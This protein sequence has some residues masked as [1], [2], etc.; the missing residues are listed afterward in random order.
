MPLKLIV[1]VSDIYQYPVAREENQGTVTLGDLH[2]NAL[3]L[4]HFLI[5]HGIIDFNGAGYFVF[6]SENTFICSRICRRR[7]ALVESTKG[8]YL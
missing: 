3:K 4:I 1:K 2:G 5:S 6:F 8:C 7:G